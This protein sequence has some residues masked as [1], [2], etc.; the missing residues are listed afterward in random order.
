M[1][2]LIS[3]ILHFISLL[4]YFFQK[5]I[6]VI[7]LQINPFLVL[8]VAGELGLKAYLNEKAAYVMAG[9]K[10]LALGK[11]EVSLEELLFLSV[12][13]SKVLFFEEM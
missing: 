7:N 5:S 2:Y 13:T 3:E 8:S 1:S 12:L 10:W 4:F 9:R 6:Y 11:K